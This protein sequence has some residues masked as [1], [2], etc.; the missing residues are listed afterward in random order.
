MPN[1]ARAKDTIDLRITAKWLA[2]VHF[3]Y[4]RGMEYSLVL[5]D[6][7]EK[8][9]RWLE[10]IENDLIRCGYWSRTAVAIQHKLR[11]WEPGV[12][13]ISANANKAGVFLNYRLTMEG[14]ARLHDRF[15]RGMQHGAVLGDALTEDYNWISRLER[16]LLGMGYLAIEEIH[17]RH[18]LV[19][20]HWKPEFDHDDNGGH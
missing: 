10:T 8:D 7:L 5:G 9:Y 17:N 13:E 1:S 16:V 12:E 3:N 11:Q 6:S 18:L 4:L 14:A 2:H 15:L 19:N 20:E